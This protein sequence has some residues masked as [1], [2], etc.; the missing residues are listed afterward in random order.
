MSVS[1]LLVIYLAF[2]SLGLPDSLL[3][4]AWP[5]MHQDLRISIS[6]MGILSMIVSIG[7]VFSSLFANRFIQKFSTQAV[8]TFSVFLTSFALFGFSFSD[9][10]LALCL[11]SLP[12]GFGAGAID[13]AL[14]DYVARNYSSKHMS[15]LHSFWGVGTIISP[16]VMSFT[17][18]NATWNKGYQ[19]IGMVQVCIGI[20]LI[21]SYPLWKSTVSSANASHKEKNFKL[22]EAL[23]VRGVKSLLVGIFAYCAAEATVMSWSSTYLSSVKDVNPNQAVGFGSLVFIGLTVGRFL[24]GFL[25]DK[26]GDR[27]MIKIGTFISLFGICILMIPSTHTNVSLVS[28]VIIGFGFAPIYPCTIHATPDSFTPS[29]SGVVIGLQMAFA[30]VGAAF[31]PPLFGL[32]GEFIGFQ[33]LPYFLIIFVILMFLMIEA[34]FTTTQSIKKDTISK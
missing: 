11:F 19:I 34:S 22:N 31:M 14:N 23:E 26:F 8:T 32:I 28:L 30:Y 3:G 13:A 7:T 27:L 5:I 16:F 15:W 9:S 10:F 4:S 25:M 33:L 21:L 2:I 18:V 17:L 6:S 1:L 20:I 24:S 12:Y 29:L